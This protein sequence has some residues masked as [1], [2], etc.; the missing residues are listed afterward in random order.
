LSAAAGSSSSSSSELDPDES[1]PDPEPDPDPDPD[2]SS[3]SSSLLE[4]E[5]SLLW[6]CCCVVGRS[7]FT[8]EGDAVLT[9]VFA[10]GVAV[11]LIGSGG[12]PRRGCLAD[13]ADLQGRDSP[14]S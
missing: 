12:G 7:F 5:S 6:C 8:R 13:T 4:L 10:F 3:S 9:V 2:P 14:N 1:E 11:R